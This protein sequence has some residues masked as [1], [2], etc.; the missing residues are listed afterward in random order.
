M[1]FL[2][3][4][5][6]V[7]ALRASPEC[8]GCSS[9]ADLRFRRGSID[10]RRR[11]EDFRRT[12]ADGGSRASRSSVNPA[13][14]TTSLTAWSTAFRARSR[15]LSLGVSGELQ[16]FRSSADATRCSASGRDPVDRLLGRRRVSIAWARSPLC[17]SRSGSRPARPPFGGGSPPSARFSSGRHPLRM[18]LRVGRAWRVFTSECTLS[19]RIVSPYPGFGI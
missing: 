14:S 2:T 11:L 8:A 1:S 5:N 7:A 3:V 12:P 9:C 19:R 13:P 15:D 4:M 18:P 6:F 17:A 16:A 10:L